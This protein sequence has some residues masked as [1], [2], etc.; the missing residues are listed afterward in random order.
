MGFFGFC[1][2]TLLFF[3]WLWFWFAEGELD[4]CGDSFG[5][6]VFVSL[7]TLNDGSSIGTKFLLELTIWYYRLGTVNLKSFISKVLLRI[8]WK[9]ELTYAL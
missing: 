6:P 9:F 8:K 5:I 2:G 4:L 3:F 1:G 7:H